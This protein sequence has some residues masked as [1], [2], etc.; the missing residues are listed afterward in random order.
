MN[1]AT[2]IVAGSANFPGK[3]FV[4]LAKTLTGWGTASAFSYP[5][6]FALVD[7]HL[8]SLP[9]Y[10]VRQTNFPRAFDWYRLLKFCSACGSHK[11]DKTSSFRTQGSLYGK[12]VSV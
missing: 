4:D 7:D 9:R 3:F 11:V 8:Q 6:R 12:A 5:G 1:G 2:R 10:I